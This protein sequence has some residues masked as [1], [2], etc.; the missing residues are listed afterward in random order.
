MGS[1]IFSFNLHISLKAKHECYDQ[2]L[3]NVAINQLTTLH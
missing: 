2:N 3:L 1:L